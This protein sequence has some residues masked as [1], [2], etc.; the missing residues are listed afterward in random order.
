M[1]DEALDEKEELRRRRKVNVEVPERYRQHIDDSVWDELE[2]YIYTGFLHE[3]AHMAGYTFVFKTLNYYETQLIN[4]LKPSR[5]SPIEQRLDFHAIFI[6]Y[7]IFIADGVNV[8]HDRPKH[9]K[10]LIQIIKKIPQG[11]QNKIVEH[12]S[13]LNE[14]ASRLFPLVEVYVHENRSRLRW[15]QIQNIPIHSSK[16]TGIPGTDHLGMNLCQS[17]WVALN[18]LLD[19]KEA[20]ERDW[21]N[22]KFIG[23]C[24]SKGVR[25]VDQ[26]DRAQKDTDNQKLEDLR[27]EVLYKYI[28]KID[29]EGQAGKRIE[30]PDGRLAEVDHEF[31][32]QS[33]DEL[34]EQLSNALSDEKD[35]HDLVVERTLKALE[36]RSETIDQRKREISSGTILNRELGTRVIGGRDALDPMLE[37]LKKAREASIDA[38]YRFQKSDLDDS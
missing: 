16:A 17:T 24:F 21:E 25:S 3:S 11:Y 20:A 13:K 26:K 30:L 1:P 33:V 2:R 23:S 7:S 37:R 32:A 5:I 38:H 10:E 9:I 15:M 4:F 31:K 6:A 22:A 27:M 35:H 19:I 28:N 36:R 8:L 29:G 14:Q 34:A 12:L 18:R